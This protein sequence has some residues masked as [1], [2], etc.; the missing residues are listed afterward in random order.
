VS[1]HK[2]NL[3][4]ILY[5]LDATLLERRDAALDL[6]D[7]PDEDVIKALL[8]IAKNKREEEMI[9]RVCGA[10]LARIWIVKGKSN[11]KELKSLSKVARESVIHFFKTK[12]PE[13]IPEYDLELIKT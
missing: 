9:L 1:M 11:K 7:F 4:K 8:E 12:K 6:G 10:S 5:N 3:I 13:W 2:S